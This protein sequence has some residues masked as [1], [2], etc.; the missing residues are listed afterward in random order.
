MNKDQM[1]K[2]IHYLDAALRKCEAENERL[3]AELATSQ[4]NRDASAF[5]GDKAE[6]RSGFLQAEVGKLEKWKK[7]TASIISDLKR[8]KA[9]A[10]PQIAHRGEDQIRI[11]ALESRDHCPCEDCKRARRAEAK[12]PQSDRRA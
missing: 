10:G 1:G 6:R 7:R 5:S 2:Q 8:F 9:W 3:I 4:A 12:P 11:A